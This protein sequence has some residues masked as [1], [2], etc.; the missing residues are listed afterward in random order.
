[1]LAPYAWNKKLGLSP[2]QLTQLIHPCPKGIPHSSHMHTNADWHPHLCLNADKNFENIFSKY[3]A[4]WSDIERS[5]IFDMVNKIHTA[6]SFYFC[7][8]F[9]LLYSGDYSTNF[10]L[11]G[12]RYWSVLILMRSVTDLVIE[13]TPILRNWLVILS[14]PTD[15]LCPCI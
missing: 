10:R 1:M 8:S 7:M 3:V 5:K 13:K 2:L 15:F 12:K 14:N 11:S 6:I 9:P 4:I